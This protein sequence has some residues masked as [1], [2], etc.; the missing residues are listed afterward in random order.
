MLKHAESG[1]HGLTTATFPHQLSSIT[2]QVNCGVC[3]FKGCKAMWSTLLLHLTKLS[4][5]YVVVK[6]MVNLQRSF[7]QDMQKQCQSR[8]GLRLLSLAALV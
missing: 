2:S 8:E 1:R 6:V 4:C 3:F 5:H 7:Q